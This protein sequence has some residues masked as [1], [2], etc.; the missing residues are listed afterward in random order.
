MPS[1]ALEPAVRDLPVFL[2]P[3][4]SHDV[5]GEYFYTNFPWSEIR[6]W[7]LPQIVWARRIVILDGLHNQITGLLMADPDF[8]KDRVAGVWYDRPG[9]R[10]APGVPVL[11][12]EEAIIRA[13]PDLVLST[14]T[15]NSKQFAKLIPIHLM[16]RAAIF[17]NLVMAH[18]FAGSMM[19]FK[20]DGGASNIFQP[21]FP[22]LLRRSVVRH[23][24][25]YVA[26]TGWAKDR[27]VLDIACGNGYGSH[28]LSRV[29]KQV[30][31]VDLNAHLVDYA[32]RHNPAA[33]LRYLCEDL[34]N[35]PRDFRV[36]LIT[37][38]ETF[39]HVPTGELD[40]F[41]DALHGFLHPGAIL[42]CTTPLARETV[43]NPDNREHVAEYST[44]EFVGRLSR[45]FKVEA[46][47]FQDQDSALTAERQAD[48]PTP[49]SVD[50]AHI[51]QIAVARAR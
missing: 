15:L 44:E 37:S 4:L 31:G 47:L 12:D 24:A 39:E 40:G 6:S 19:L 45:R 43:R 23:M 34:R 41:V 29:A 3:A 7:L 35:L 30:T 17:P 38:V 51:V 9:I 21:A 18:P 5:M 25:R 48:L 22:E 50:P 10:T 2:E 11:A 26:F 49:Q 27:E 28:L 16:T 42:L 20:G 14:L 8:P 33:N 32:A 13:R 46:V 36:D 1:A